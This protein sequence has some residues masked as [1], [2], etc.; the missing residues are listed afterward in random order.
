MKTT[1]YFAFASLMLAAC[2]NVSD[3]G[4]TKK[5]IADA[6]A[7]GSSVDEDVC[8]QHGWNDDAVC[9]A[10]CPDGDA[11]DCS[12]DVVCAAFVEE[13]NGVCGR[14]PDDPCLEQDPDCAIACPAIAELPDGVCDE[15]PTD[16]CDDDPDCDDQVCPAIAEEPDG[17]CNEDPNEP[18]PIDPDCPHNQ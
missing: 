7:A 6:L 5:E 12:G 2:H 4:P 17:V 3:Q 10:W 14:S 11:S 16:P 1:L 9:D 13:P 18:C 8:A 15:D